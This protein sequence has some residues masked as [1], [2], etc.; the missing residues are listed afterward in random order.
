V[1]RRLFTRGAAAGLAVLACLLPA[2]PAGAARAPGGSFS[3][4]LTGVS[5]ADGDCWAVG[6]TGNNAAIAD[7]WNGSAW[8]VVQLPAP[9]QSYSTELPAIS[10]TSFASCWAVG[11]YGS[12]TTSALL[13]YA[14]H[15]NGVAWSVVTLPHPKGAFDTGLVSV[16]C[17]STVLC[18][19]AGTAGGPGT[20]L[21]ERWNGHVWRL[22]RAPALAHSTPEGVY[23][24]GLTNCWV[25]G[26]DRK[27]TLAARWDGSTW[28][29]TAT[30]PSGGGELLS[31]SCMERDCMAVGDN[32]GR[33]LAEHWNGSAWTVTH[34]WRLTAFLEGVSC[35]KGF[36]CMATGNRIRGRVFSEAWNG[37]AW[38]VVT[39]EWPKG[40]AAAD[41]VGVSCVNPVDCWS[42][43]ST[44]ND[45][46]EASL[47]EHWNGTKWSIVS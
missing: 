42:V 27:G 24:A 47:I 39:P 25:T 38:R 2:A 1:N 9:P 16:S 5:C 40:S 34:T 41:L 14:E 37:S 30:P 26:Y 15:W 21:L 36:H 18:W 6:S 33:T 23:C 28:S 7:H 45:V 13:P 11:D 29:L 8:S 31:L 43:G 3:G 4:D 17:I 10:C 12:D 44:F 46:T 35:S 22:A 20:P 19:A 32:G